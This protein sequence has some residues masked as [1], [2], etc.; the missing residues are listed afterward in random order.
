MERAMRDNEM[1]G[2]FVNPSHYGDASLYRRPPYTEDDL[3]RLLERCHTVRTRQYYR[4]L[5]DRE[6]ENRA[7]Q[8]IYRIRVEVLNQ[9]RKSEE[10]RDGS[11]T[12]MPAELLNAD[13]KIELPPAPARE[14]NVVVLPPPV[15]TTSPPPDQTP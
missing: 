14:N 15:A 8:E 5:L 4:R 6:V 11:E 9:V 2:G 12:D 13:T 3:E 1:S 10:I 7:L